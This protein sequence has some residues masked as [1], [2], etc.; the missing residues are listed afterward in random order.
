[1][2]RLVQ[3]SKA[4]QIKDLAERCFEE[5]AIDL[6]GSTGTRD[7]QLAEKL[8]REEQESTKSSRPGYSA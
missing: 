6:H 4:N 7:E 3:S 2:Q 8:P 1:M 5:S